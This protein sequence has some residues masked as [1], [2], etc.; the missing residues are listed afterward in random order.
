MVKINTEHYKI[1]QKTNNP[2]M[3]ERDYLECAI[4]EQ[5]FENQYIES[6]FKFAGG[7]SITKA[8]NISQ[9]IG[10]DID[11]SCSEFE[12]LPDDRSKK[13]LDRFRKTFKKFVF[14]VLK[15]KINYL[16]NKDQQFMLITDADWRKLENKEE[17]LAS[18]SLHF[19]YKSQFCSGIGH[20][21]LEII[22]RKYDAEVINYRSVVPYSIKQE[23]GS[24][25]TVRY[26]QTFWDKIYA[27]HSIANMPNPHISQSIS[28][29]YYDV[30]NMSEIVDLEKT[31][32]MLFNIAR[33]QEK[34]TTKNLKKLES[35]KEIVLIPN[36]TLLS[37][38]ATDYSSMSE[39]F[40][41]N[42]ESWQNLIRKLTILNQKINSL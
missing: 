36:D 33:Y 14:E 17:F 12:E 16:V 30:A 7:G 29:H 34:Y 28:R 2:I 23:M 26:E 18:P 3:A 35:P 21:T 38:I 11:L 8:Y 27:L 20:L 25:P 37:K 39:Q 10:Q 9:R 6:N 1:F 15:P 5:L 13:Q 22:P 41:T 42:P 19:I 32:D 24:I 4:L 40:L 31:K